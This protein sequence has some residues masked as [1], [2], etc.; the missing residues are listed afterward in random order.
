MSGQDKQLVKS[1]QNIAYDSFKLPFDNRNIS[2]YYNNKVLKL[3]GRG[4]N[5]VITK[6]DKRRGM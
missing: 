6:P 3:L 1:P 4:D 5:I 2:K